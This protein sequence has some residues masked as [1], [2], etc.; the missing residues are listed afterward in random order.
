MA[1]FKKVLNWFVTIETDETQQAPA[2]AASPNPDEAAQA[3][4]QQAERGPVGRQPEQPKR[5]GQIKSPSSGMS[6]E[7]ELAALDAELSGGA[8]PARASGDAPPAPP[9]RSAPIERE[10]SEDGVLTPASFEELYAQASLPGPHDA[11]FSIYKVEQLLSS[12]HLKGLDAMMKRASLLVAMQ[13]SNVKVE[14]VIA[15]AF[16]RDN[17]L[18]T[19]DAELHFQLDMLEETITQQNN[20]IQREVEEML[21]KMQ[22]QIAQNNQTLQTA[23]ETYAEWKQAKKEEEQRLYDVISLFIE[24]GQRNPVSVDE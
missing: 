19:H 20:D 2:K 6:L 24:P 7:E 17:A 11:A 23:R 10:P 5:V 14:Q 18:D 13:A 3:A 12:P 9:R 4:K 8:P 1:G 21:R 16:E 22:E 15:D